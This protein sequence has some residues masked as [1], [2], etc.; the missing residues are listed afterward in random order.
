MAVTKMEKVTLISDKRNQERILQAVQG[1]QNV[2]IRDLYQ[3]RTNNQW[4]EKY[5]PDTTIIDKEAKLSA[6]GNRLKDIQEAIQFIQ[7]HGDSRQKKL[8]LKRQELSLQDLEAN[9]SEENFINKLKEV[10][11]LKEKW[12]QLTEERDRLEEEEEWLLHWQQL[13]IAPSMYASK[14]TIF[15]MGTVS[16]ANFESFKEELSKLDDVYMEEI[17]YTPKQVYLSYVALK[18]SVAVI[19][20]IAGKYG[21]NKETYPY[22]QNPKEKLQE[23]K[24]QLSIVHEQQKKI[25]TALGQ[26]S[27]YI[28][29][30]EWVEEVTLAVAEREKIKERFIHATYLIVLQGWVDAEEKQN[31]LHVLNETVSEEDIY[32]S[33]ETPNSEEIQ[34]EVPTKLKNHPLVEPFELLTEMYSL[35]KY[36]EVDPTPW[37]TPFYLVFFGMMVADVGYGLLMLIGTILAQ[38]LLVLPRGMKRFVKFFEILSIPSIIWGLI[39][40]SFFG[41]SLPKELFGIR[42][43]FPI[44]STTDDVNTILILSVIFGLIQILVGLFVAAKENIRRKDYLS[45]VSDGFAWQGILIGIVIALVGAMLI[46]N[47]AFVYLGAGLSIIAALCILIVPIIQ[48]PSKVKGAAKGAYNLYGLTGYIGDLVSYTRLMALGISGGSIGAAFNMLVAFMPPAARFSVGILLIIALHALN[49]FLT[50][51]SAYVHGARLQYV[52]FFGKFYTGGGRAFD[53][54]KTAEKYVNI[55]HKKKNNK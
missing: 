10:L 21:F 53:P 8:H 5:F 43:P 31:L 35:P 49:M 1:I 19:E 4:V 17:D 54:L 37:M 42:V 7:H 51:L 33:F 32:V 29:E 39:Y 6:L 41:Q 44:L 48:T 18:K 45:A 46:K 36:E 22:E 30:F 50:L 11:D 13:D 25:T 55:N 23:T 16:A 47:T 2:E 3:N 14:T 26:C 24:Q 40:S 9:Y 34:Q 38:K 15:E 12:E 27:G 52:E 20:E 28:Q